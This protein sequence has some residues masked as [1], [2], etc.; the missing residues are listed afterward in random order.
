MYNF[1]EIHQPEN[2]YYKNN[3]ILN[4]ERFGT[5][6]VIPFWIADM[7]F[8]IAEPI[9][10]QLQEIVSRGIYAYESVPKDYYAVMANWFNKRHHYRL[11]P[12]RFLDVPGILTGIAFLIEEF[13]QKGDAILIQTPV[14]H[15]FRSIIEKTERKAVCNSLKISN[16]YYEIDFEDLEY[17]FQNQSVKIMILCNPHN[18][19]GRVWKKE[20][21]GRI[22]ALTQKY[23]VFLISD[24]VHSEVIFRNRK[25]NSLTQYNQPN[26]VS[27]LGS[28]GKTF[29]LQSIATGVFYINDAAL[30][31]SLQKR[32]EA[33]YLNHGNTFSRYAT[34]AAYKNGEEWFNEMLLYIE[35]NYQWIQK[36]VEKELPQIKL[37][38][39]EGTYLIWLDF[40][41]LNLNKEELEA[42]LFRKAGIG[43]APGDWFGEE[44]LGFMRMTIACPLPIIQKAF[45]QLKV[46]LN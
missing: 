3:S 13:S 46:A 8:K 38:P 42:L 22:V 25:F 28:A 15:Q 21:I 19:V 23:R 6:E 36:F 32:I 26:I 29:G 1:D 37:I 16:N 4:K 27:I 44:G 11:K 20:E 35:E 31:S 33:L 5:D 10:K 2:H 40:R 9:T 45:F 18:P 43:F 39:L 17:Q 30:Q 24:E 14:Y 7:D 41:A 12:N 34:Y